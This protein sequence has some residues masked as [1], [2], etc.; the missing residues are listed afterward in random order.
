MSIFEKRYSSRFYYSKSP[1][2]TKNKEKERDPEMKST[3]K[4]ANYYFGMKIH[5]WTDVD[6]G[7]VH[8][9]KCTSANISD[10]QVCEDLLHGEEK[11]VWWDKWYASKERKKSFRAKWIY[12]GILDKKT[13]S[14]KLSSSQ[15]KRNKRMQSIK[16][17]VELPFWILKKRWWNK[18]VRYRWLK[19]THHEQWC[20]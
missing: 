3:K 19:K 14:S 17:K 18:K 6:T 8:T 7:I 13:R 5:Q 9:V 12:Y 2:S 16:A 20:D 15:K 4:W 10:T 11:Y 1:S